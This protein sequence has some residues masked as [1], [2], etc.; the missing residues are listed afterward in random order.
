MHGVRYHSLINS[1]Q[2][3]K[4]LLFLTTKQ[5]LSESNIQNVKII[6]GILS[7]IQSHQIKVFNLSVKLFEIPSKVESTRQTCWSV[8]LKCF[9]I[10]QITT[11]THNI[12]R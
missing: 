10:I 6:L 4:R 12:Y 7:L 8:Q 11:I 1:Y 2:M 3:N 9:I 5:I